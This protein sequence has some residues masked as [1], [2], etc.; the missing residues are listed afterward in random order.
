M[1]GSIEKTKSLLAAA[2]EL[3]EKERAAL[4]ETEASVKDI[5][6]IHLDVQK[7]FTKTKE[8]LQNISSHSGKL[9]EFRDRL[10]A[11]AS[12]AE[13]LQ[14]GVE[15]IEAL[16]VRF[17]EYLK[18]IYYLDRD[19]RYD[20]GLARVDELLAL[21]KSYDFGVT[22]GIQKIIYEVAEWTRVSLLT[23]AAEGRLA[24]Q[25]APFPPGEF[26]RYV[27]LVDALPLGIHEQEHV[28]ILR[29]TIIGFRLMDRV[30]KMKE[31]GVNP[32]AMVASI[33][34]LNEI[35]PLLPTLSK[36]SKERRRM[37][38]VLTLDQFNYLAADAFDA[39]R[40][41]K[42]AAYI[43]GFRER[44]LP[45]EILHTDYRDAVDG[46][47]FHLR[48]L[49]A[50]AT[51]CDDEAFAIA[52]H[53][54]ATSIQ[55][56]EE[57][58]A[59]VLANYLARN[60]LSDTKEAFLLDAIA[61]MSFP[62]IVSIMAEALLLGM[63]PSRQAKVLDIALKKKDKSISL[64]RFAKPL[65]ICRDNLDESLKARYLIT[66]Q[67]L[68]RS[69][70]AHKV[71]VKSSNPDVHALYGET[72]ET[73]RAPWGKPTKSDLVKPCDFAKKGLFFGFLLI[74]PIVLCCAVEPVLFFA[75]QGNPL[76]PY[77]MAI[78]P[79]V[80]LCFIHLTVLLRHGHDERGSALFR[81]LLFVSAIWK[82]GLALAYYLLPEALSALAPFAVGMV[83]F[84]GVE[85]L[86]AFFLLKDKKK[87]FTIPLS[88]LWLLFEGTVLTLLIVG[89]VN[90]RA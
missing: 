37:L 29:E 11:I 90:G 45:E 26:E 82:A 16:E 31:E 89:I 30:F 10:K 14:R 38:Y 64:D 4:A 71:C 22:L 59:E 88:I 51:R 18:E 28:D 70:H 6:S 21:A 46:H 85:G 52:V 79:V 81:R 48:F 5:G 55:E 65:L 3:T 74:L 68:L 47:D 69:P 76:Q 9:N 17:E 32:Q 58:E 84:A 36:R 66:L 13:E 61:T 60:N 63:E 34:L 24:K 49:N 20:D 77:M 56:P 8:V 80:A 67:D 33:E 54:Y 44:F 50:E 42:D 53:A 12:K 43:F 73:F 1:A 7:P 62:L 72:Q 78:P 27:A 35:D 41:Y 2:K 25:E 19:G 86:W 75:L 87:G 57:F 23:H 40:E 39:R 15:D 83:I